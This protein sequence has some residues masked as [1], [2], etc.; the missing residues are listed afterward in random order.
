MTVFLIGVLG[1]GAYFL[2]PGVRGLFS[3]QSSRDGKYI[4]VNDQSTYIEMKGNE[5]SFHHASLD[6]FEDSLKAVGVDVPNFSSKL[7]KSENDESYTFYFSR[8][9]SGVS[10]VT[11]KFYISFE[12]DSAFVTELNVSGIPLGDIQF[13]KEGGNQAEDD[14]VPADDDKHGE[15]QVSV[16]PQSSP[17][18]IPTA[19]PAITPTNTE[20]V[21]K[22]DVQAIEAVISSRNVAVAVY[23]LK[24]DKTY[25]TSNQIT[26][27]VAAGFYAPIFLAA[28]N[29][30]YGSNMMRTMDNTAANNA[31]NSIGGFNA[32]NSYLADQG[33]SATSYNRNF[34]QPDPNNENYTSAQDAVGVLAKVYEH[35]GYAGM[36][37][38]LQSEGI[39]LPSGAMFY[40]HRGQGIGD[41]FNIFAYVEGTNS[42][43]AVAI[44]TDG[45]GVGAKPLI[46]QILSNVHSQMEEIS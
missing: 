28:G 37:V 38:D 22:F 25:G 43:Y 39:L 12:G 6:M 40:A 2:F 41:S 35:S 4:A 7:I 18:A 34:G 30:S 23:D 36:S 16:A 29:T 26:Q 45:M 1:A 14:G 9:V 8:E 33:F 19:T 24:T 46:G 5:C 3:V 20:N 10:L 15:P 31:I 42:L 13:V 27:F 21:T 11:V 32:L 17:T 44:L